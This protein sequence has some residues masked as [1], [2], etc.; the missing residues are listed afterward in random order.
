LLDRIYAIAA[1]L[2]HTARV[3]TLRPSCTAI[4]WLVTSF[5]EGR[6][7]GSSGVDDLCAVR[8]WSGSSR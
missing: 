7:S 6:W 4:S 2:T 5:R 1:K 8:R 3:L